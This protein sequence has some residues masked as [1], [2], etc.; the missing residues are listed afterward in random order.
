MESEEEFDEADDTFL[1]EVLADY[2]QKVPFES[3]ETEDEDMEKDEEYEADE[4]DTVP[5]EELDID[6]PKDDEEELEAEVEEAEEEIDEDIEDYDAPDAK[7]Y[8][9]TFAV[10]A[11]AA[12]GA[13]VG[14]FLT[15]KGI[16]ALSQMK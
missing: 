10:F 4:E 2:A 1:N 16:A 3:P 11:V 7:D 5:E 8:L 13:I 9:K 12:S 15:L 14:I 6:L